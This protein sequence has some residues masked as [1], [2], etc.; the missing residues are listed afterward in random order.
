MRRSLGFALF[1]LHFALFTPARA[2][3][4]I[5]WRGP[6]QDG[7]SPETNLPDKWSPDPSAPDN[8][9]IWKAGYGCRSTPLVMNGRV[10]LINHLGEKET[11]QERVMCLDADTGKLVWEHR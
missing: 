7:S 11:V 2:A 10:F 8:N 5:H 4:W 6:E 3:D 9:L 1:I